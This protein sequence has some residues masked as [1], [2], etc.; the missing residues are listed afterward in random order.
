MLDDI[1]ISSVDGH[2]D[3]ML[4]GNT[5]AVGST[6]VATSFTIVGGS[7][8]VVVIAVI[9]YKYICVSSCDFNYF[10]LTFVSRL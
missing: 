6:G 4:D 8:G 10:T 9:S 1:D 2:I 3:G 5:A 7:S